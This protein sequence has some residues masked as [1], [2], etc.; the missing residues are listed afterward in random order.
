MMYDNEVNM[1][2]LKVTGITIALH[3][4]EGKHIIS[5]ND[6]ISMEAIHELKKIK[7]PT[8]VHIKVDALQGKT[9]KSAWNRII[10]YDE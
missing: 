7:H 9:R 2:P 10:L 3:E 5:K 4:K 1:Q 6:T 8:P